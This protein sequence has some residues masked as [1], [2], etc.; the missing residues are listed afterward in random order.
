MKSKK[1]ILTEYLP[2][3]IAFISIIICSVIFEQKII[4]TLPVCFSLVITLLNSRAN[5]ICYILG[6][7]NS[8]IYVVGYLMEGLYGS[9]STAV[10]GFVIQFITFFYWKKNSYKQATK[11][12][13]MNLVFRIILVLSIIIAIII[14]MLVLKKING[15]E[16]FFDSITLILG[17]LLPILVLF[18]FMEY[19]PLAL[20]YQSS[21]LVMWI[22]IVISGN[23][24]NITYVIITVYNLYMTIR[25]S[26]TWI[27]MYK[28]QQK[29]KQS[30][31]LEV[32]P[33][34]E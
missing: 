26:I 20:F 19:I 23:I 27:K 28:E 12:R 6:A 4:K 8:L 11:F 24:A 2:L 30:K 10:F 18:A 14:A 21:L 9:V 34:T 1:K 3:V 33:K 29:I 13:V 25:M 15:N 16:V 32:I 22:K 17:I 7:L 5:R 31:P